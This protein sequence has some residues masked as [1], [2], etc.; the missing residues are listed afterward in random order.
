MAGNLGAPIQADLAFQPGG[1]PY[2][3]GLPGLGIA[4]QQS[5]N[6][7]LAANQKNYQ[8]IIGGYDTL[9]QNIASTLG[10]TGDGW[11]IAQ[12]GANAIAR[13]SAQATGGALQNSINSGVGKSTAAVAAQRGANF[14][15]EQ[16]YAGL[17]NQLASTYAGYEGNLG[18][19]ELGFMNSI[20]EPYP[21]TAGYNSLAQQYGQQQATAQQMAMQA[22]ALQLQK[23]QLGAGAGA[24]R[25]GGGGV[26]IPNAPRGGTDGSG[27]G[28]FAS[29]GSGDLS[30]FGGGG[31]SNPYGIGGRNPFSGGGG[32]GGYSSPVVN[33]SSVVPGDPNNPFGGN[34][35]D[36]NMLGEGSDSGTIVAG[37]F[38]DMSGH[39]GF[40]GMDPWGAA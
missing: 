13:Q 36:E 30:M 39:F 24:G 22:Q 6:S 34:T 33:T 28:G 20:Q 14:D 17:G 9:K 1:N 35:G 8:N 15:T 4:Y 21:D 16:A 31:G 27:G 7:A 23:R 11:G 25:S 5:Y 38:G 18:L 19:S 26:S 29:G 37:G 40:A 12:A 32:G 2:V 10:Q 3:G